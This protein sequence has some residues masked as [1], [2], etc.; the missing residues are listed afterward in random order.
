MAKKPANFQWGPGYTQEQRKSL[1]F[2]DHLGNN[3][4]AR[5]PQTDAIMVNVLNTAVATGLNIDRIKA[6]MEE[7]GYRDRALHQLDRWESKRTTGKF[8]R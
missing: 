2:I 1:D 3:G 6:A 8:G 5:N 4:W 7:I